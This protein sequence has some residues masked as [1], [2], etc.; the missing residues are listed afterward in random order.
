MKKID[1]YNFSDYFD[2]YVEKILF[3]RDTLNAENED[4]LNNKK[5]NEKFYK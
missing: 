4:E 3:F 1:I 2:L 5:T